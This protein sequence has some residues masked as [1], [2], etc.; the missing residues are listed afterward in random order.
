MNSINQK[1][2][3]LFPSSKWLQNYSSANF[4]S[5]FFAAC[6]VL[7]MLVPQGMAYAM[8]AGLPPIMGIYASILPMIIYAFI[9]SSTTLSVGPVAIISMMVFATLNPLFAIGTVAYIEAACLLS[10]LVGFISL[11]LGFFRFGFLIQLISHPVIKSFVIASALLIALGQVKFLLDTPL[12]ANNIP[13]FIST[14]IPN[15]HLSNLLTISTSLAA[16]M[17]LVCIPKL[18]KNDVIIKLSPL[19]LV[20]CSIGIVSLLNLDQYG[21]KT[22]GMIP[23]GL[24]DLKF[25]TWNIEL[26]KTLLPSA[27][28]IAMISFVESLAIAQATAIKKRDDLNSN[29]ELI[30]LG[31][32]NIS[33]GISSG[34]AVSGSLS[35]TVVNADAGAKTPMSGVLSSLLMIFVGLYFTGFFQNLPLAILAATILVSIWKLISLAPFI[36]TWKYSKADGLAML[37]TFIGVTCINISTGLVIGII[38]T[39]ILLLWRISRPHI[40]QIGLVEGTQHFRNVS[41]Y[42]V[43]TIPT[44]SSFRVDENLNFLNAHV[45][46]GSVITELSKNNQIQHVIINCSSISNIDLSALEM[47]EELN[48]ELS[49]L[50]IQLHL[51]EVKSPVMDRLL[52]S[53][54]IKE[55]TGHIFLT[56]YQAIQEISVKTSYN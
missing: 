47:L 52:D 6:I 48:L 9:G 27:F 13:E 29:Q 11:L 10:I 33:A 50:A 19:L 2:L 46:K 49:I 26:V 3:N 17:I 35:R 38:L 4:K 8:L 51:S 22:V 41:R 30:A 42:D 32:A 56:H 54:L 53:R 1:I 7:T 25:P 44:I 55:L 14:L 43:I 5:D 36:E 37:A 39:F 15:V 40:A 24:P 28:M 34:F 16:I 21:L 31:L 12:K 45:L 20:V 18:F 23:S